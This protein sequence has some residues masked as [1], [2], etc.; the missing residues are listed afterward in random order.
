MFRGSRIPDPHEKKDHS[1]QK[2]ADNFA[3]GAAPSLIINPDVESSPENGTTDTNT[4]GNILN[5]TNTQNQQSSSI[6][7]FLTAVSLPLSLTDTPSTA[8][9]QD[10]KKHSSTISQTKLHPKKNPNFAFYLDILSCQPDNLTIS[11]FYAQH[12]DDYRFLERSHGYIQ[13]IFPLFEHGMNYHAQPLSPIEVQLFRSSST[14]QQR[15]LR[16]FEI[17]LKFWGFSYDPLSNAVRFHPDDEFR[18]KRFKNWI[19]T[20]NNLRVSRCLKSLC[21]FGLE[22]QAFAFFCALCVLMVEY[23][24]LKSSLKRFWLPIFEQDINAEDHVYFDN[25]QQLLPIVK[26]FLNNSKHN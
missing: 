12:Q 18:E 4:S 23:P 5:T 21:I 20:H 15:L 2:R 1:S 25:I 13:W 7:T 22:A 6:T 10:E 14:C 19:N 3:V 16:S 17:M 26:S 9:T 8:Q 11:E 24:S